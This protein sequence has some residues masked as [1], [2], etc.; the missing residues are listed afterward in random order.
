MNRNSTST[1]TRD[2]VRGANDTRREFRPCFAPGNTFKNGPFTTDQ[3]ATYFSERGLVARSGSVC[4]P[5][6]RMHSKA[7]IELDLGWGRLGPDRNPG[8][9]P[10]GTR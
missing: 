5:D 3:I 7:V 2:G 1:W 9:A 8:A 10:E 4:G 6:T